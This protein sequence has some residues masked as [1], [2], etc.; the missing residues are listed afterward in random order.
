MTTADGSVLTEPSKTEVDEAIRQLER[1]GVRP[2]VRFLS[3][4]SRQ[5]A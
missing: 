1:D 3:P 2:A 4:D 5:R